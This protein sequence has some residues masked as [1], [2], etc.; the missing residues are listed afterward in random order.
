[1]TKHSHSYNGGA[2]RLA[3]GEAAAILGVSINTLRRWE[4][5]GVIT[6]VRTPGGQRRFDR[7]DVE[8]LAAGARPGNDDREVAS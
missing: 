4:S 8:A 1:M 2:E 7:A 6:S 5:N 3:I